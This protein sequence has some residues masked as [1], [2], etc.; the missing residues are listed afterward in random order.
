MRV[1][2]P[3]KAIVQEANMRLHGWMLSSSEKPAEQPSGS[4]RRQRRSATAVIEFALLCP[5]LCMIIMGMFEL[6]RAMMVKNILSD[7]ARKACRTGIQRD[8]GNSD[9][10][11]E[12]NNIMSDNGFTAA[13]FNPPSIGAITITVTDPSGN[14]LTDSLDAPSGTVVSVQ[15]SI[16]VSSTAWVPVIFLG[17]NSSLESETVVMMK[18]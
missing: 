4:A 13:K 16:P 7:A 11:S 14:T 10:T 9:I 18:Q 1:M 15:V 3:S 2:R 6:G 17:S 12:V 5:F 8:K